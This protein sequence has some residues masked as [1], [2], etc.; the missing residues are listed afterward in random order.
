MDDGRKLEP[1]A[2]LRDHFL[3]HQAFHLMRNSW[4]GDIDPAVFLEPH[5]GGG[6]QRIEQCGS[7]FR[8]FRLSAVQFGHFS[9][10][11]PKDAFDIRQGRAIQTHTRLEEFGKGLFGDIV[12]GRTKTTGDQDDA[13]PLPGLVERLEDVLLVIADRSD[14][15]DPDPDLVQSLTDPGTVGVDDLPDQELVADGDDFG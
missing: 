6:S 5:P 4:Q 13:R 1:L 15:F 12:F 14:L 8:Y 9:S 7:V 3:L 2:Q 10:T 11:G